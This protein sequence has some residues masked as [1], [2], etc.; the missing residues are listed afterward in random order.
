MGNSLLGSWFI[1][2]LAFASGRG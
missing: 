2:D 1:M